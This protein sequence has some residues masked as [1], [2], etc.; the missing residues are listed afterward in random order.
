MDGISVVAFVV[1][2]GMDVISVVAFVVVSGMDDISVAAFVVVSGMDVISVV[3]FVV[4]TLVI[5][6]GMPNSRANVQYTI[7]CLNIYHLDCVYPNQ[8][9]VL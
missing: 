8:L 2:S 3:G 7:I 5:R 9:E 6:H 1:V 4:M